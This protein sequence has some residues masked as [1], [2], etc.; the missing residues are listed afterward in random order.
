MAERGAKVLVTDIADDLGNEVAASIGKS[1]RFCHLDTADKSGW[2]AA[3]RAA[4][5]AFGPVGILANSAG[6]F[7]PT[8]VEELT[9]EEYLVTIGVNQIGPLLGIQAVLPGMKRL[10]GGAVVITSSLATT[11][12]VVGAAAYCASKAA[13]SNMVRVAAREL[14]QYKVRVNSIAPG[15]ID[16]TT[17]FAGIPEDLRQAYLARVPV[18][19]FGLP[20]DIAKLVCFLASEESSWIS[21]EEI[22]I[23]GGMTSTQ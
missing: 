2:Q 13:I 20:E 14:G 12:P 3:V 10:G 8:P 18:G 4:E 1:A 22:V 5:E 11:H 17:M 9:A 7:R 19:R 16:R 15:A 21:G 23:D 6:V